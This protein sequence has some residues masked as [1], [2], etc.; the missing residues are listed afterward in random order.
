MRPSAVGV[1]VPA[2]NEE[3]GI[4]SCLASIGRAA[5]VVAGWGIATFVVVAGDSCTD[6]TVERADRWLR[7][8]QGNRDGGGDRGG[9]V[10]RLDARNVGAA[11]QAGMARLLRRYAALP[12]RRLW[13]AST[14][15][16]TVVPCQWLAR[17]VRLAGAGWDA[18]AGVVAVD[19]W[20]GDHPDGLR[21]FERAY[22]R[23]IGHLEHGHVHAANLGLRA[24]AY[25]EAG[26]F[27]PRRCGEDHDLWSRLDH[28]RL[29]R[30]SD[31][32]LRVT[33]SGRLDGRAA[34][35]FSRDLVDLDARGA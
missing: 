6:R 33:T 17:Q 8:G 19:A 12:P 35:G 2:R 25:L 31:P 23:R 29:R 5:A 20:E 16:D 22:G 1:V 4:E 9:T 7:G 27:R 26:G 30:L 3:A 18:V 34:G 10:I 14:D 11:R 28:P 21:G 13:L 15:A 24:S 32:G